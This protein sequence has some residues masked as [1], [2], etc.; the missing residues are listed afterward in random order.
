MNLPHIR[1]HG[2]LLGL[3]CWYSGLLGACMVIPTHEHALLEGRGRIEAADMAFLEQAGTTRADVALRFGEPDL[4]LSRDRILVYHWA[5]SHGY[6]FVGGYTAAAAG[7][8]S[9]DYL[10]VLEFDENGVLRRFE[11]SGSIWTSAQSRIDPW[12]P[13]DTMKPPPPGRQVFIIDPT[14]R[15]LPRAAGPVMPVR[16]QMGVFRR[17]GDESAPEDFLGY[18]RAAFGVIVAEVRTCRPILDIVRAAVFDQLESAGHSVVAAGAPVTVTGELAKFHAM[19]TIDF[20]SWDAVSA[21]DLTVTLHAPDKPDTLVRRY[22]S[23]QIVKT[24]FG[25]DKEDFELAARAC[26]EDLQRQMSADEKLA[27]AFKAPPA[28]RP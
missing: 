16:V 4:I 8:I 6:W 25:P 27:E 19:T 14:P 23:R 17:I 21:L 7:P 11:P 1:I 3:A 10:L 2:F 9:K 13:P 26:L 28:R 12:I 24:L 18:N 20:S 15:P 22:H 5:V